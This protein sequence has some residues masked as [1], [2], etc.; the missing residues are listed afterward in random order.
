MAASAMRA[1]TQTRTAEQFEDLASRLDAG[2]GAEA[3]PG[4]QV[5]VA[6]RRRLDL[7][8]WEWAT[9]EA[10]EAAGSLPGVLRHLAQTHRERGRL[11]RDLFGALSYPLLV[12]VLCAF[13]GGLV[14]ATGAAPRAWI[15]FTTLLVVALVALGG[16]L[17]WRLRDPTLDGDR[18]P[19]VGRL[20]RCAAELPYLVALRA[21]YAAGVPLR[22][23]HPQAVLA[24]RVPWVKSRLFLATKD[25]EAGSGFADALSK[26]AALTKESLILVRDGETAGQ[27]EDA[28]GRAAGRRQEEYARSMRRL[29]RFV[30]GAVY[31]YAAA[32]V[33][34]VALHFYGSYFGGLKLR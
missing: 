13:V 15:L 3:E 10:A 29:A 4:Q 14:L 27:L 5:T 33:L 28:L 20:S 31:A 16:W 22:Q 18:L 17:A 25:L 9:L 32:S 19:V 6:M 7:P 30:G 21:L 24:T 11:V 2:L 8:E 23:A 34:W 1:F 26:H 12:L